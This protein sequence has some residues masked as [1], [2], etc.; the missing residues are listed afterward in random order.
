MDKASFVKFY[1]WTTFFRVIFLVLVCSAIFYGFYFFD[2]L[3][4]TQDY[5]NNEQKYSDI[6]A[7]IQSTIK[8]Q[9][10]IKNEI[11]H[12]VQ[13]QSLFAQWQQKIV[14]SSNIPSYINQLLKIG[15]DNNLHFDSFVPGTKIKEK[16]YI[17]TPIKI[18]GEGNYHQIANFISNV[19]N[20]P[21]LVLIGDFSISSEALTPATNDKDRNASEGRLLTAEFNFEVYSLDKKAQ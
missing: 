11:N 2:I 12:F 18:T 10:S 14:S 16:L 20:M 1:E 4:L 19:A 6:M 7:S 3:S 8:K 13:Q 17:K 9:I 15:S 5:N 21:F